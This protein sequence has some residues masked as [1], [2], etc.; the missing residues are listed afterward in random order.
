MTQMTTSERALM[1][2]L[3]F[4]EADLQANRAGKL[5]EAQRQAFAR[6]SI[7]FG[8]LALVSAVVFALSYF[9]L[10]EREGEP[11]SLLAFGLMPVSLALIGFSLFELFGA[12]MKLQ[13]DSITSQ[14]GNADIEMDQSRR[15]L[16]GKL[17]VGKFEMFVP[18][19]QLV[20]FHQG[21]TYIVYYTTY[22]KQILSAEFVD[23]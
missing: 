14:R 15:R 8:A 2:A 10:P 9:S 7:I 19:E 1:D 18:K 16:F 22:P 21:A 20:A 23:G 4:T 17:K 12:F 6:R 5:S 13:R 11:L 3:K